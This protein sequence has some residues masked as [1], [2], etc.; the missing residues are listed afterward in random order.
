[1]EKEVLKT[2]WIERLANYF[3]NEEM[4]PNAVAH[5]IKFFSVWLFLSHA[6]IENFT[7]WLDELKLEGIEAFKD[8]EEMNGN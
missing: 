2:D 8:K 3:E 4:S 1:M 5:A 7:K 6:T